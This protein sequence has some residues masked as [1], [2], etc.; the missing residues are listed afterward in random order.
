LKGLIAKIQALSQEIKAAKRVQR[1]VKN[2]R[3]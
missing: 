3:Q 1:E 2:A